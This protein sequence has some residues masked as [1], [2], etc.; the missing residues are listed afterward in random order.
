MKFSRFLAKISIVLLFFSFSQPALA[1][2]SQTSVT[3]SN[4][5][6]S[7]YAN[8]YGTSALSSF[9]KISQTGDPGNGPSKTNDNIFPNDTLLV[10]PGTAA[11]S[12]T[13]LD[14]SSSAS[15]LIQLTASLAAGDNSGIVIA[16]R[17]SILSTQLTTV[18]QIPNGYFRIRVKAGAFDASN[19]DGIP[20]QT[21]FD[22]SKTT[23]TIT[24]PNN[25]SNY[26]FQAGTA[27]ASG[28]LYCPS[29]Y[30]C[31]ECPYS[32][33]GAV[34]TQFTSSGVGPFLINTNHA[35]I[36]PAPTTN[37]TP[38]TADSYKIIVE[39]LDADYNFKDTA[40]VS[41]T[42]VESV[43]ITASVEPILNFAIEGLGAGSYCGT[44]S[45]TVVTT[46]TSVPF[47]TLAISSFI[48]AGQ[49]LRVAT[50][51]VNGYVVVASSSGA[52]SLGGLGVTTIPNTTCDNAGCTTTIE[53]EWSD[54]V[55]ARGFGYTVA[56]NSC[57]GTCSTAFSYNSC[58]SGGYGNFC[59]RQFASTYTPSWP[60]LYSSTGIADN[61]TVYVCYRITIG[62]SQA[63]GDYSTLVTYRAT[64]TF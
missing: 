27:T 6:L 36:N 44:S 29:G 35:M 58:V 13:V 38:G 42:M 46:A 49:Q 32:G 30:H 54:P 40:N 5:R 20:D 1:A 21:G 8:Q 50:N 37:H 9:I 56:P 48:D 52:L 43:R 41:I 59:S 47:G 12:Y 10:G 19:Q 2:L 11:H 23:P 25:N 16:T 62:A 4:P 28:G 14:A 51:A 60:E 33:N 34:G 26:T 39:Q 64:A 18:S 63:A 61:D 45:A 17:S 31:F 15:N 3:L 53:Q 7:F 24:C 55:I 57:T 22:F